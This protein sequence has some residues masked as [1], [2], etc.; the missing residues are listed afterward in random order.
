M[1][2]NYRNIFQKSFKK[3]RYILSYL[4]LTSTF[5]QK[6]RWRW[7]WCLNAF[8]PH[9]WKRNLST[10]IMNSA[11]LN[12]RWGKTSDHSSLLHFVKTNHKQLRIHQQCPRRPLLTLTT[13]YGTYESVSTKYSQNNVERKYTLEFSH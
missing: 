3:Q 8:Q 11:K 6:Q 9:S 1:L 5:W 7:W 13:I 2:P 10:E 4:I 12:D